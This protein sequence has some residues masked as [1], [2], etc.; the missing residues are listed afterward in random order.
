MLFSR[1]RPHMPEKALQKATT[2]T[3]NIMLISRAL[4]RSARKRHDAMSHILE[5]FGAFFLCFLAARRY[6]HMMPLRRRIRQASR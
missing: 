1:R 2:S 5:F 6:F 4:S 3:K